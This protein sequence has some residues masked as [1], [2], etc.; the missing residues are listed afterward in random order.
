MFP[1][2][3]RGF[4]DR[5]NALRQQSQV[6]KHEYHDRSSRQGKPRSCASTPQQ[7]WILSEDAHLRIEGLS[8]SI[9]PVCYPQE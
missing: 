6:S 3:L 2:S 7:K 4:P 1:L 8:T 5:T 9:L